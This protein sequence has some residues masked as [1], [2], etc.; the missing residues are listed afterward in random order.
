MFSTLFSTAEVQAA[1]R[2]GSLGDVLDLLISKML[3]QPARLR[4]H[5]LVERISVPGKKTP[6]VVCGNHPHGTCSSGFF[7]RVS[8]FLTLQNSGRERPFPVLE[9]NVAE[10]A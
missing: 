10:P 7:R 8:G 1:V 9:I 3:K 5:P 4:H 6:V 2:G